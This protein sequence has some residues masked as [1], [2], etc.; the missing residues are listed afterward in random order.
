MLKTV[1]ATMLGIPTWRDE[2]TEE[3]I[4]ETLTIAGLGEWTFDVWTDGQISFYP[5]YGA[6]TT[7][8][9]AALVFAFG[10]I[11]ARI[12]AVLEEDLKTP[13]I[14]IYP[15]FR[16][17]DEWEKQLEKQPC[18]GCGNPPSRCACIPY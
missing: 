4:K 9:L 1:S 18:S 7:G 3:E 11:G 2:F 5:T 14:R 15:E 8:Q 13:A 16:A 12:E 10:A 6:F 17:K